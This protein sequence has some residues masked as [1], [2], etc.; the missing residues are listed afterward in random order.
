VYASVGGACSAL[1]AQHIRPTDGIAL[2]DLATGGLVAYH[3][4][5]GV[6][7]L[8]SLPGE[9]PRRPAAYL[10]IEESATVVKPS[11]MQ[12]RETVATAHAR[13]H[14]V[15]GTGCAWDLRISAL[16]T[17]THTT[18][19]SGDLFHGASIGAAAKYGVISN[20]IQAS[21]VSREG[22]AAV[23][24]RQPAIELGIGYVTPNLYSLVRLIPLDVFKPE[25]LDL[26]ARLASSNLFPFGKATEQGG[27]LSPHLSALAQLQILQWP[28]SVF[29]TDDWTQDFRPDVNWRR[30]SLSIVLRPSAESRAWL[31]VA[32]RKQRVSG[33]ATQRDAAVHLVVPVL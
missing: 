21:A 23:L 9:K 10:G 15:P 3:T 29:W 33:L 17:T 24:Q 4:C 32:V 16:W 19:V 7:S 6:P 28:L 30:R 12:R 31:A 27:F 1:S 26:R 8:P 22:Y 5:D 18:A 25:R 2:A 14:V 11:P 20:F 13:V